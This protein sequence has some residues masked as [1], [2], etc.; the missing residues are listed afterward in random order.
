MLEK[1][2]ANRVIGRRCGINGQALIDKKS[3]HRE[4][5]RARSW[6]AFGYLRSEGFAQGYWKQQNNR[7]VQ[8]FYV[9]P[10]IPGDAR[11]PS[12]PSGDYAVSIRA[13]NGIHHC[14]LNGSMLTL[15]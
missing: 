7:D 11:R 12:I 5:P 13:D 1:N 6:R 14:A 8:P 15:H 3:L 9:F 4:R 2:V 10:V